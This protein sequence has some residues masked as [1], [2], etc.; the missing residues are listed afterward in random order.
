MSAVNAYIEQYHLF[1]NELEEYKINFLKN[2][3][4]SKINKVL[5]CDFHD[6]KIGVSNNEDI[7]WFIDNKNP[8]LE[9]IYNHKK[10]QYFKRFKYIDKNKLEVW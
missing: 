5:R 10:E 3:F 6:F 8:G 9:I 1:K 2:H 4:Y 7:L